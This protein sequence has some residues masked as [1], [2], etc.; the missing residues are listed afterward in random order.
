MEIKRNHVIVYKVIAQFLRKST[1]HV[2][3]L[4][5]KHTSTFLGTDHHRVIFRITRNTLLHISKRENTYILLLINSILHLQIIVNLPN[6]IIHSLTNSFQ[7][8]ILNIKPDPLH[9]ILHNLSYR[10]FR[11][12]YKLQ[13]ITMIQQRLYF[14]VT[15][16]ITNTNNRY[17]SFLDDFDQC[18]ITTSI[19]TT[20][21]IN[22]VHQYQTFL[23]LY[24]FILTKSFDRLINRVLIPIIR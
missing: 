18:L 24:S 11:R 9:L 17:L 19:T 22:F 5:E 16:I 15:S 23:R 14:I 1:V 8:I 13:V 4:I 20:H 3:F 12:P 21:P 7:T 6:I 10:L 2:K